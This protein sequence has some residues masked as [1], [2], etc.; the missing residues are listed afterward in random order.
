MRIDRLE[1]RPS[2]LGELPWAVASFYGEIASGSL[3]VVEYDKFVTNNDAFYSMTSG[4]LHTLDDGSYAFFSAAQIIP[5]G[6]PPVTDEVALTPQITAESST[7]IPLGFYW[8]DFGMLKIT[9]YSTGTK[10][11]SP[12]YMTVRTY[13]SENIGFPTDHY[14][15]FTIP[16]ATSNC[17]VSTLAV[18][19]GDGLPLSF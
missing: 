8:P 13:N 15:E 2:Q 9:G 6:S 16:F 4:R 18:R 11:W 7:S 3:E 14:L 12:H 19:L 1:K 10:S 17:I 5:S